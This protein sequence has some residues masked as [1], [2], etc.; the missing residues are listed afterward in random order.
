MYKKTYKELYKSMVHPHL[1]YANSVWCP[2]KINQIKSNLFA[3][4]SVHNIT[5]HKFALCLAGQTSHLC[6]PMTTKPKNKIKNK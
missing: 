4:S 5:F 2:H 3:I 6:L 1:E